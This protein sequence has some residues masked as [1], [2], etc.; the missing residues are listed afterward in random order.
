MKVR[1]KKGCFPE[2]THDVVEES[3]HYYI[4]N[5]TPF[6]NYVLRKDDCEEVLTETWRDVTGEC[7]WSEWS[8]QIA[9]RVS[10]AKSYWVE[11]SNGYRLRKVHGQFGLGEHNKFTGTAFIVEKRDV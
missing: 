3:E 7:E 10:E 11:P 9:H 8:N 5:A 6:D 2:A 1:R 4:C